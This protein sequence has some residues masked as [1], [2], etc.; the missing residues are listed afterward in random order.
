MKYEDADGGPNVTPSTK[1]RAT[2]AHA[3][4]S[5][6]FTNYVYTDHYSVFTV[7]Y[8]ALGRYHVKNSFVSLLVSRLIPFHNVTRENN[9]GN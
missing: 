1:S 6:T 8:I 4:P 3:A 7:M 2:S 5:A 9:N